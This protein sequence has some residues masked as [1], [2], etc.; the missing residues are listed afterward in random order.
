MLDPWLSGPQSDVAS[1]FSKQSHAIPP[2]LGSIADV[3]HLCR[4]VETL[5]SSD[6]STPAQSTSPNSLI[7][8]IVISHE[9]T[10][11][12]HRETLEGCDRG[13]PVFAT[14]KAADL[15]KGWKHFE[16]VIEVPPFDAEGS[17]WR[18]TTI[19]PLPDWISI[20]RLV[21]GKDAFYYHSAIM[22]TFSID[23]QPAESIIYTP[24]GIH[25]PSLSAVSS[26]DPPIQCLALLHGLHDVRIDW[27]QQLNL[28][29]HNGLAAQRSLNAKYWIGT[30]DEVKNGGGVVSWF[31]RRKQ[32][33]LKD[34]LA[35]ETK[36]RGE[37][38][39]EGDN[40][41]G[42]RHFL[43]MANGESKMLE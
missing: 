26:A 14:A 15:I 19:T 2:A 34:A 9:F 21:T 10:D 25:A 18:K 13:V 24:H 37:E 23:G 41:L 30:H 43:E 4:Q 27:G 40:V 8:A 39:E 7:D 33:T 32:Y 31:L 6:T 36:K 16:E 29:A 35:D 22:V 3:E 17:D 5:S 11:H 1:W 28:G 38:M 20:I 42:D 12:C